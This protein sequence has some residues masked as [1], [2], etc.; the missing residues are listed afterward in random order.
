MPGA[1]LFIINPVAGAGQAGAVWSGLQPELERFGLPVEQVVTQEKGH[2]KHLALAAAAKYPIVV[3]VGGDGTVSEVAG[4][5]L[6]G[7]DGT[8][9]GIVPLGTGNDFA[10]AW[11]I[12]RAAEG[13]RAIVGSRTAKADAIQVKY[14]LQGR[15][16]VG[17]AVS[18]VAAGIAAEAQR[19]TTDALKRF[20]GSRLAYRLGVLRALW[21][22]RAPLMRVTCDGQTWEERVLLLCASNS[23]HVG[24]GMRIA[25]GARADDGRFYVNL[26]QDV[27]RWEA[28]SQIRRLSHGRHTNHPRVRYFSAVKLDVDSDPPSE[29]A[30]DGDIIGHTP[31]RIEIRHHALR[32]LIPR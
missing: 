25:P 24:G 8:A 15:N 4:G 17:H 31:A 30:A 5:I 12:H 11:G 27:G 22:Y 28:L 21:C 18:F 23:E 29:V 9:L 14:M 16:T 1:I 6:S 3:A 26:V 32:V 19:Q 7:N 10:R 20:F 13:L 2:A